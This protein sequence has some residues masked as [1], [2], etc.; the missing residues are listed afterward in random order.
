MRFIFL[1][2]NGDAQLYISEKL[3]AIINTADG[4]SRLLDTPASQMVENALT[5][6]QRSQPAIAAAE[7][8]YKVSA[9]QRM[10][11]DVAERCA[12]QEVAE[13][14]PLLLGEEIQSDFFSYLT[15]PYDDIPANTPVLLRKTNVSEILFV[16]E[17]VKLSEGD[18]IHIPGEEA[19][20]QKAIAA[21]LGF[22]YEITGKMIKGW[23]K[24]AAGSVASGALSKLGTVIINAVLKELLGIDDT[25]Q[26]IDEITRII[27][28]EVES[29]EMAKM[30]GRVS[31]TLQFFMG[32][33]IHMRS[34]LNLDK[35]EDREKLMYD[36]KDY[37]NRFYTDVIGILRQEKYAQRGLRTFM[38]AAS[39]HLLITQ[40]MAMIDPDSMDPNKSGYLLTLRDNATLYRKH[41]QAVYDRAMATR[42]NMEVYTKQFVECPGSSCVHKTT[43]W[44]RDNFSNENAGEFMGTK[45]PKRSAYEV[46]SESLEKHRSA[47]LAKLRTELG[48][49]QETFLAHIGALEKFTFP[50]S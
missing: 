7:N 31:G 17:M 50:K 27:K 40:E 10:L 35:K 11:L 1:S 8:F 16:F 41:V 36:L 2:V 22:S 14:M 20:L 12:I 5:H 19:P 46:A 39:L 28:E 49:P 9:K 18:I 47:V 33:Y 32:E 34:H 24:S 23:L 4:S 42:N 43:Y 6:I 48:N 3:Q 26:M 13:S 45:D 37:S 29:N 25:Q 21:S 38:M 44:W 30:E 15:A